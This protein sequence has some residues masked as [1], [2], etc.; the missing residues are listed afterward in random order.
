MLKYVLALRIGF[1]RFV[2]RSAGIA[3]LAFLVLLG[4]A[5]I[6]VPIIGAAAAAAQDRDQDGVTDDADNCPDAANGAAQDAQADADGDSIGNACE[7]GD[8]SGDGHV[9]VLDA[10]LIDRCSQ[11]DF[12]CPALCDA[13]GDGACTAADAD[14]VRKL[15]VGI[16]VKPELV[17]PA[18]PQD[19]YSLPR[20]RFLSPSSSAE[21]GEDAD[22]RVRLGFTK[23]YTGDLVFEISGTADAGDGVPPGQCWRPFGENLRCRVSGVENAYEAEVRV[24]LLDDLELEELESLSLRLESDH[25]GVGYEL[26]DGAEHIVQIADDDA[27]WD[28]M[29]V[30]EE[31]QLAF[32]MEVRRQGEQVNALLLPRA[33]GLLSDAASGPLPVALSQSDSLFQASVSGIAISG[34]RTP[35]GSAAEVDLVLH[36]TPSTGQLGRG[37]IVGDVALGSSSALVL[38]VVGQPH[39][40]RTLAGSFVLNRRPPKPNTTPVE[41]VTLPG[42]GAQ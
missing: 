34:A 23:P 27:V 8:A 24:V 28:G 19:S 4:L 33:G 26:L 15:L 9:D 17:C 35:S 6:P 3:G 42:G 7:C 10:R 40:T 36:A 37:Q 21:E 18:R 22:V 14:L 11:G 29:F 12:A 13:S 16:L 39:L 30:S 32:T 1:R 5:P 31:Q 38:R 41:L 2:C 20:A 25:P